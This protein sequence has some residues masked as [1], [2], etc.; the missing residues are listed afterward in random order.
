[1]IR[2]CVFVDVA[3]RQK[4]E[5]VPHEQQI[6]FFGKVRILFLPLLPC[7]SEFTCWVILIGFKS[8]IET[9]QVSDKT[10]V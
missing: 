1:M 3:A 2:V 9:S 4:G 8:L 7:K 10:S 5:K 6:K